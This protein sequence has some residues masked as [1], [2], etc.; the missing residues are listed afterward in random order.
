MAETRLAFR[1]SS[2]VLGSS[3]CRV[4]GPERDNPK[5]CRVRPTRGPLATT[6]V[7]VAAVRPTLR[8][9][10]HDKTEAG[11]AKT[12]GFPALSNPFETEKD[13]LMGYATAPNEKFV[14]QI[15]L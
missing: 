3:P 12:E 2:C 6:A 1:Q 7:A 10:V 8:R 11:S 4:G 15:P 13:G 14:G 5:D 9:T